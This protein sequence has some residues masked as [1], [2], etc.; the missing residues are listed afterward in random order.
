MLFKTADELLNN[1]EAN[2]TPIKMQVELLNNWEAN[3]TPIKMQVDWLVAFCIT[4]CVYM[5]F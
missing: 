3:I 1:W 5:W 2:T 4:D